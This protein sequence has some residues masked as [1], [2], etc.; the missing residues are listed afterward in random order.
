MVGAGLRGE[1]GRPLIGQ[2]NPFALDLD[3]A[4]EYLQLVAF[5]FIDSRHGPLAGGEKVERLRRVGGPEPIFVFLRL[6]G[7]GCKREAVFRDHHL[8]LFGLFLGGDRR[9]ELGAAL[10]DSGLP[11]QLARSP[12]GPPGTLNR[13]G[14][15]CGS[16]IAVAFEHHQHFVL[17]GV[18]REV[19]R[20][21]LP[22]LD[23]Q[24]VVFQFVDAQ[25]RNAAV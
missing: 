19:L 25:T 1:S 15:G 9:A 13:L 14:I 17:A 11:K 6:R 7:P 20:S 16:T 23:R 4:D 8:L 22:G 3:S 2:H 10:G 24:L 12:D 21:V 5:E 18:G